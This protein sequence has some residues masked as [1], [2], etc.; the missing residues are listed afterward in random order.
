MTVLVGEC[1]LEVIVQ[2][3]ESALELRLRDSLGE[4]RA[5]AGKCHRELETSFGG[6]DDDFVIAGLH[7]DQ[8]GDV[9]IGN[10]RVSGFWDAAPWLRTSFTRVDAQSR[11]RW[12]ACQ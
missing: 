12:R 1:G 5:G 4:Q 9:E 10:D 11:A 3:R 8:R 6:V 7:D 2:A